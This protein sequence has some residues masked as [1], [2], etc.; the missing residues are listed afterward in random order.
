MGGFLRV[1]LLAP[2]KCEEAVDSRT[3]AVKE[4]E[5]EGDGLIVLLREV[6]IAFERCANK[7]N[8]LRD[9]VDLVCE[10]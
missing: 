10:R 7:S 1:L 6:N 2:K 3:A 9:C 4:A 5:M 8:E